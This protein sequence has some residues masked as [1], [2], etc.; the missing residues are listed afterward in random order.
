MLCVCVCVYKSRF[1]IYV[2][3][4]TVLRLASLG[5]FT[6]FPIQSLKAVSKGIA[7]V[8]DATDEKLVV[9]VLADLRLTCQGALGLA[10]PEIPTE[11][12]K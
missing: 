1:H 2:L 8:M 11:I 12:P 6:T 10:S 5:S 9:L 3:S 4:S 7:G